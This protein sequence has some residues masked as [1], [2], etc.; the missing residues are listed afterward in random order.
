M[1]TPQEIAQEVLDRIRN[2]AEQQLRVAI[3][4]QYHEFLTVNVRQNVRAFSNERMA[5]LAGYVQA[6]VE[7]RA[8]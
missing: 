5:E 1:P 8:S 3:E 2:F 4:A 6:E 7:R